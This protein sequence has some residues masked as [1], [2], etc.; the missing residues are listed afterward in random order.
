MGLSSVLIEEMQVKD[1]VIDVDNF[2]N[3]P[4]ITMD[5]APEIEVILLESDGKPRGMGEPPMGPIGAAVG[6]A[7]FALTGVRLRQLPFKPEYVKAQF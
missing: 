1:G 6:N 4:L 2:G 3:Y 5:M 7:F